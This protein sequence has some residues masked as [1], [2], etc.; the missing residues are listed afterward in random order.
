VTGSVKFARRSTPAEFLVAKLGSSNELS[1]IIG[2][3]NIILFYT[4]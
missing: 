4:P 3:D 1:F 2:I